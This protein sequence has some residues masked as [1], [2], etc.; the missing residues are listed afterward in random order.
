MAEKPTAAFVLSLIGGIFVLLV[1]I[2]FAVLG[3]ILGSMVGGIGGPAGATDI[4][5]WYG[6]IGFVNGLLMIVFGVLLYIR[7]TQHVVWGALV[8][9]LSI[10]SF[11]TTL[12]GFFIG[13]ILGLIGGILGIVWKP[14]APMAGM[15]PPMMPPSMPPP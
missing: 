6:V 7:P 10:A 4:I 15:A 3:S 13:L 12:G 9:I 1:G 11:F 8:L 5:V 2:A 14:P